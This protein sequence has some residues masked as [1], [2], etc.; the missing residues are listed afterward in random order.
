MWQQDLLPD[1]STADGQY[2]RGYIDDQG[3]PTESGELFAELHSGGI[4]DDRGGLTD[5]GKAFIV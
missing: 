1:V 2:L 5:K 3:N 4:F